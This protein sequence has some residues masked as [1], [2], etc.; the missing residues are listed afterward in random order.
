[1][2]K[3]ALGIARRLL[4]GDRRRPPETAVIETLLRFGGGALAY[5]LR[6]RIRVLLLRPK[7]CYRE[8]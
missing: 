4:G 2:Q 3:D 8:A 5:A 6:S 7:E 1:M